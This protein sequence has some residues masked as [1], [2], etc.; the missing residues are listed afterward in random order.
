MN[1]SIIFNTCDA[2]SDLWDGFFYLFKKYWP[3]YN[4]EIIFNSEQKKYFDPDLDIVN[5]ENNGDLSW[6]ERLANAIKQAKSDYILLMMDD[7]YLKDH[8]LNNEF[9]TTVDF[10][11]KNKNIKSI[12]YMNE[13]GIKCENP[14]DGLNGFFVRNHFANYK[15]TAHISLYEKKYLLNILRKGESAWDFEIN[16]TFRSWLKRGAFLCPK[17]NGDF[18]FKYDYGALVVRDMFYSPVK[19]YFE[20]KENIVFS[21]SR[22]ITD[23]MFDKKG[24]I[25]FGRFKYPIR[26][27]LSLFKKKCR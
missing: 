7:F 3:E 12:T 6:S 27:F 13:P 14:I 22:Q 4:G 17:K 24:G 18:I 5:V 8:V 10:M 26:A 16:G 20:Q 21:A 19:E 25:N 2:Y 15:M 11:M 23:K 1:C 9:E